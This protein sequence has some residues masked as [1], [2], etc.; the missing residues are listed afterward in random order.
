MTH[1]PAERRHHPHSPEDKPVERISSR[2]TTAVLVAVAVF[3]YAIQWILLPFVIAG[4]LAY[5]CTPA[6]EFLA[7]RTRLP[8]ILFAVLFFAILLGLVVLAGFLAVPVLSQQVVSLATDLEGTVES[9]V[10]RVAGDGPVHLLGTTT[11]AHDLTQQIVSSIRD[12][13]AQPGKLALLAGLSFGAFFYC[14][15][16]FVLLFYFLVDGRRIGDGV[17]LMIPPRQRPLM[18]EIWRKLDPV[19]KRY[20]IGVG[21]V[22]VYASSAAY[23][24]LGVILGLHYSI[25]LAIITGILELIPVIGPGASAVIAGLVA[26]QSATS[27]WSILAYVIYAILLRVSIDQLLG[28]VVLGRAAHVHPTLVI[29]CFLSGGLLFGIPGIIMAL[30]VAIAIKTVLA[31]LYEEPGP[32]D[33]DYDKASSTKKTA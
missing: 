16:T 10:R 19:L 7:R 32:T 29:F 28:P 30:P 12:V 15:L 11:T 21:I 2:T 31:S 14:I 18:I 6:V 33:E 20:F 17:F 25:F 4:I 24:G 1:P 8:R 23:V 26:L 13:V 5:V 3:L 27:I 9:L 22:V